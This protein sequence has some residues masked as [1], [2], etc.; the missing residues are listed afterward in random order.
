V[1]RWLTAWGCALMLAGC[2]SVERPPVTPTASVFHDHLF[3]AP[4]IPPSASRLF[5]M[6]PA[7]QHYLHERIVPQ[8]RHKGAQR[9]LLD[10][11]YT[12]GELRLEYDAKHTRNAEQAFEARVGNCLSLVIMTASFARELGLQV[13]FQEVLEE[14]A[15]EESGDLTFV[16]GHVNLALGTGTAESRPGLTTEQRWLV[17]D[18]LPG[19]DLRRQRARPID[20]RRVRALYM[21]NRAAEELARGRL[22]D[23]YWWVRGAWAEDAGLSSLY[24]TLGV[25]YRHRGALAEAEQALQAARAMEPDNPHVA[26]N[27]ASLQQLR[28][29]PLSA[30][31]ADKRSQ[32]SSRLT[33]AQQALDQGSSK[34]ALLMLQSDLRIAPQNPELHHWLAI[35][36]ARLG[37]LARA[38]QHLALAAEYSAGNK[39]RA[40]Y[41]GKLERLR[42]DALRDN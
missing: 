32:P 22:T 29:Y 14:H 42:A 28:A 36:H 13:R 9:A 1:K 3:E 37:N 5:A 23:A 39:Q 25:I 4:A 2:A 40:R 7:M 6:T 11:L 16:V 31:A 26:N 24:N 35:T 30:W 8:V 41:T 12:Q 17:V 34:E 21:N 38:Q 33:A 20:E 10:A 27:L 19:Q 15:I 18:F